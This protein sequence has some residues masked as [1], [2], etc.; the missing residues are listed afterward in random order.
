MV[1]FLKSLPF[2]LLVAL[3]VGTLIGSFVGETGI[4]IIDSVRHISREIVFF[5]VPLII[6][7]SVAPSI[8]RMGKHASRLLGLSLLLAYLSAVGAGFFSW[9]MG[10]L[11]IPHLSIADTAAGAREMPEMIFTLNILPIMPVMSALALALLGGLAVVWTKSKAFGGLLEELQNIV[12]TI[13][14]KVIIPILPIFIGTTF[15]TLAFQGRITV[16]LP[17]FLQVIGLIALIHIVWIGVLCVAGALYSKKNPLEV[18]RH[19]GPAYLTAF[20]TMSSAATL[21]VALRSASKAKNLDKNAVSFGI[22]LFA[23]IHMPG[24]IMSITFLALTVS[25]ILYGT[26]PDVGTMLLFLP[27]LAIFAVAAPGVPG[28]TLMASLGLITAVLGFGDAATGLMLAIFA[29]QDSFGTSC[30]ITSDAPMMTVLSRYSEKRGL[31]LET[32]ETVF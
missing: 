22:P 26:M 25:R 17:V 9:L 28:G 29:L 5:S 8:A 31:T 21:P 10:E 19:Y 4:T 13:V 27:L 11:I 2:R 32:Q 20:G 15:A 7:G 30:N 6:L 3:V 24:S 12:L 23:H 1:R 18:L 16:Q 14:R